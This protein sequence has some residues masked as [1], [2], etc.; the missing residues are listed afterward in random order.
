MLANQ[1]IEML[2]R[3]LTKRCG[4]NINDAPSSEQLSIKIFLKTNGYVSKQTV[5]ALFGLIQHSQPL[6]SGVVCILEKYLQEGK[7]SSVG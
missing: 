6:N 1:D 5:M 4:F 3:D 2:K 7:E